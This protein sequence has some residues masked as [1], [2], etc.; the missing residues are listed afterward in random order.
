MR[1]R[2]NMCDVD[3]QIKIKDWIKPTP[4]NIKDDLWTITELYLKGKYIDY[5]TDCEM[6]LNWEV[7]YLK[8]TLYKLINGE[9]KDDEKVWFAEPDLSFLIFP[10]KREHNKQ[11]S[12]FTP[13][14][15]LDVDDMME[16]RVHFW[17]REGLGSNFF[18]MMFDLDEITAFFIY[19]C[20]VTG[21]IKKDDARVMHLL[22]SGIL[23]P[24]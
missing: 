1:F 12:I 11:N 5:F 4:D 10:A 22:D 24:E 3:L 19:L 20:V 23:L 16:M 9:L 7:E 6:M 15:C 14:G 21:E 13:R 18:S 2:L 17:C 8:D